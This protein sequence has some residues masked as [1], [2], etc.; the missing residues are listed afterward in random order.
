LRC[1]IR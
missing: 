1:S